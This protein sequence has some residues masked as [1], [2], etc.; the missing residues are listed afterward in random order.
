VTAA[1]SFLAEAGNLLLQPDTV[2]AGLGNLVAGLAATRASMFPARWRDFIDEFRR[3]PVLGTLH[4]DPYTLRGYRKPRGY[5]GD[6]VLIDLIYGSGEGEP[7]LSKATEVGRRIYAAAMTERGIQATRG[8]RD[9]LGARIDQVCR[10]RVRPHILSVACGHLREAGLSSEFMA[11]RAGRFVALDQDRR[12]LRVVEKAVSGVECLPASIAQ[13][14]D[15]SLDPG[16]FDFVYAAGLYD[17]LDD[18]TGQDLLRALTRITVPGGVIL[19]ANFR[20]GISVAG[21]ME[22]AMDWWLVYREPEELLALADG[23][24]NC[25]TKKVSCDAHDHLV[26]LE[27]QLEDS[28]K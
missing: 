25:A 13:L 16:R 18:A 21:Y 4:Q 15:S 2:Q 17:Y 11:G 14:V 26:Y 22:A 7:L 24:P 5:A 10:E 20:P 12:S 8:R 1:P 6:A 27:L 9:Y 3:H 23:I 28:S 19:I